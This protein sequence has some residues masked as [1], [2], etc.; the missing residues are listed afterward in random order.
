MKITSDFANSFYNHFEK[1]LCRDDISKRL[2][3]CINNLYLNE[4]AVLCYRVD[5]ENRLMQT[6]AYQYLI[7]FMNDKDFVMAY[8]GCSRRH[9]CGHKA[10][11]LLKGKLRGCNIFE[12][13]LTEDTTSFVAFRQFMR[14]SRY[15]H[16][17]NC[18]YEEYKQWLTHSIANGDLF[19]FSW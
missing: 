18:T 9:L 11:I 6:G 12:L 16:I 2:D 5:D 19:D 13:A 14:F 1:E 15:A 3:R 8:V 10:Q 17:M 4:A 7:Q